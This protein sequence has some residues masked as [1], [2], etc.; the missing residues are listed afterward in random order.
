MDMIERGF[1]SLLLLAKDIDSILQLRE[2]RPLSVA[3]LSTSFNTLC[4][5]LTSHH[6]FLFLPEPL[7]F[8]LIPGQLLLF[9]C[10]F[11]LLGFLI[12][13]LHL[14][15]VELSVALNILY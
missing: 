9:C 5:G 3:T 12:P 8:L 11:I 14:D 15:L 6:G 10:G 7:F 4:D 1:L 2:L 13:I